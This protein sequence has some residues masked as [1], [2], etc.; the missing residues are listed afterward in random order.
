VNNA[1]EEI[2]AL[3][4]FNSKQT[5]IIDKR[6]ESDLKDFTPTA[7]SAASIVL[8]TYAPNKITYESNAATNQMAV[9][10][11]IYYEKGWNAYIDGNLVPHQRVNYVLRALQ[12]PAGKHNIDFKFE[13][14]V[15]ETG[16]TIAYASSIALYL[17]LA[18]A[19]FLG[20][21]KKA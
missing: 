15:V 12:V 11:E 2:K 9:F 16:E 17:G 19:L 20:F 18:L 6:F 3:T 7:D 21:K 1:D 5:A 8:L 14:K 10:S 13:P 4:G